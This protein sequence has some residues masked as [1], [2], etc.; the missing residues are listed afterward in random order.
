MLNFHRVIFA[1]V[2]ASLS[3]CTIVQPVEEPVQPAEVAEPQSEVVE[4]AP[5]LE[6]DSESAVIEAEGIEPDLPVEVQPEPPPIPQAKRGDIVWIQERLQ[7]LGYYQGPVDGSVGKATRE[8][9]GAY[10]VDQ[11]LEPT[12]N[13]SADLRDFMWRN[14][15]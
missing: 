2:L 1:L 9:I 11:G 8:A 5:E 6:A 13:P 12:G 14:G 7:E 4:I 3:A 10:Q 15:G